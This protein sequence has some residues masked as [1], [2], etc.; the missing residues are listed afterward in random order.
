MTSERNSRGSFSYYEDLFCGGLGN[1]WGKIDPQSGRRMVIWWAVR[2][3][4][5]FG[6]AALIIWQLPSALLP[7]VIALFIIH[8]YK[9]LRFLVRWWVRSDDIASKQQR[10]QAVEEKPQSSEEKV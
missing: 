2:H 5:W 6:I 1:L 4:I 9:L 3:A 7:T 8:V 10:K